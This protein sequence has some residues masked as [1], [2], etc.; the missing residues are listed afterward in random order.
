MKRTMFSIV[1]VAAFALAC[2]KAKFDQPHSHP[3]FN[4]ST[5]SVNFT[6]PYEFLGIAHNS[7]LDQIAFHPNFGSLTDLQR[8]AIIVDYTESQS[9]IFLS[10]SSKATF[11]AKI[12]ADDAYHLSQANPKSFQFI[13]DDYLTDGVIDQKVHQ[14]MMTLDDR[15]R[16][17][18]DLNE[19]VNKVGNWE[20]NVNNRN[21]INAHDREFLLGLGVYVRYSFSYWLGVLDDP[22]HPRH[23]T[24]KDEVEKDPTGSGKRLDILRPFRDAIGYVDGFF[25]HPPCPGGG[26]SNWNCWNHHGN[27]EA[28]KRSDK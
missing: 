25:N 6:N 18:K 23:A 11:F 16:K 14:L 12:E 26:V 20:N 1:M 2:E 22:M 10:E 3:V 7:A 5:K 13:A 24:F 27:L 28:A 9:G 8:Y 4:N 19:L 21:D 15:I 17:S